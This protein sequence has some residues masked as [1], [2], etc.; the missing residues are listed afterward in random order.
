MYVAIMDRLPVFNAASTLSMLPMPYAPVKRVL[1]ISN[2][3]GD[4]ASS[5]RWMSAVKL[6]R[7]PWACMLNAEMSIIE[8]N[9]TFVFIFFS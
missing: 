1:G 4:A 6:T 7:L 2:T 9:K 3:V 8:V 5:G